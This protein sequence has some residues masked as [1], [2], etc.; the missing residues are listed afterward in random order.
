MQEVFGNLWIYPADWKC[1]LTNS[2]VDKDGHAIMGAGCALEAKQRFPDLP[3][4]LGENIRNKGNKVFAL[5]EQSGII[6]LSFPTKNRW[7]DPADLV[8]IDTSCR[9][10][11]S[12]WI[13]WGARHTVLIPRPGVGKGSLD[14]QNV[15]PI[16]QEWFPEDEFLIITN[17][18]Q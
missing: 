12:L 9:Q 7:R 11:R 2:E 5:V 3:G 10:L 6:F 15:K 14:W 1:I 13:T 18:V 16:C 4:L 17:E 8:L